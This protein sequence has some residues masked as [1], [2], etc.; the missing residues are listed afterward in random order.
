MFKLV[1]ALVLLWSP[2]ASAAVLN[3]EFHF[4][5]FTGDIANNEVETVQGRASVYIN[6]VLIREREVDRQ[7]VPVLFDDREIAATVWVPV[8]SLGPV[9][10]KGKNTIRVEFEP[11]DPKSPY[12]AQFRWASVTDQ[13]RVEEE[14]PGRFSSTNQSDVGAE[15]KTY[16]GRAVMERQFDADFA[17][18]LPWHHYPPVTALSDEDKK[19]LLQ[20]VKSRVDAFKPDFSAF[21]RLIEGDKNLDLAGIK[22]TKCLD[23]AYKAGIR[24]GVAGPEQ[25]EFLTTGNPEVV[26][27]SKKGE[28]YFPQDPKVLERIKDSNTQMCVGFAVAAAYPPHLVFVRNPGGKWELVY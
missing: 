20:L 24:I 16:T 26:V 21:Y 3:V 25:I 15:N 18:D 12:N 8:K 13:E 10:R 7:T 2:L 9:V 27:R 14:G 23:K 22:K 11:V 5:P 6:N 17:V 1:L 19:S 28:L 4:T